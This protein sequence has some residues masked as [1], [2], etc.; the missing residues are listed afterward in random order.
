MATN[1]KELLPHQHRMVKEKDDLLTR[2]S[3]LN[4]FMDSD[5]YKTLPEVDC[6]LLRLQA[7]AMLFYFDVLS[8]RIDR[9]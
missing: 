4:A 8:L 3:A 6:K 5:V 9:F 1:E 2:Y 7:S